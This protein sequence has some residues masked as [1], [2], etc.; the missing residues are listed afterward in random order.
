MRLSNLAFFGCLGFG[1]ALADYAP[2]PSTCGELA[3]VL[4]NQ[5][6]YP[7][8]P[9]YNASISSYPFLQLRL[10]PSCIVQPKSAHDVSIALDILRASNRTR[11]A[12]KG[13]GHNANTGFNNIQNGVTID[14]RSIKSVEISKGDEV[15]R[16]G[17]GALSQD[18]YDAAEKRNLTVLAGRIGVVGL[19]GF[20]TGGGISFYSPQFGWACD[21]IVNFEVVLASGEIVN[22]N[23]T[24][25]PDLYTAL[26]GG[27]SN[28]GIV[29]RFDLKA[30]PATKIW[31]GR[32]A[33]APAA[34]T[35]LLTAFT[36]FKGAMTPDPYVA[37][38]VTVRY[39]HSAA[40]FN[41]VAIMWNTKPEQKPG[42]LKQITEIKPQIL[43]GMVEAPIS[44]H[45]RNASRQ[46]T[47]APRRTIWATTSFHI[48]S[49]ILHK[50]HALWKDS[51]TSICETHAYADPSAELTFQALPGPPPK[52]AAPNSLGISSDETSVKNLVF[53]QT[54]FTFD[55]AEA[56]EGLQKGLKDLIELIEELTQEEGVYHHYKYLNFAAWFQDPLGSY[57]RKQK[58]TL[59][60]VARKY[61]PAGVFQKQL[62]GGFKLL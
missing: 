45:T 17:A 52:N 61:D 37:G 40:L 42:G 2:L 5:V 29:T 33:Y 49:T 7:E 22:A 4:P 62:S 28:F 41:P 53:L 31:G 21:S 39:N 58:K 46:V 32:I 38:W 23:A 14:M 55:G 19:G 1:F 10:H 20:L 57:G 47:A 15:I 16:V 36:N 60:S 25:R 9:T 50:I 27:Q 13:G 48:S 24:S 30:Y 12:V 18:A 8:A 51:I 26:K 11:F 54:V 43:N 56:T 35:D 6:Y 44:E 59:K 3:S 34:V